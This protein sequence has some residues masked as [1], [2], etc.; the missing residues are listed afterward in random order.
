[1]VNFVQSKKLDLIFPEDIV[2]IMSSI[3]ERYKLEQTDEEVLKQMEGEEKT[4]GEIIAEIIGKTV[5]EEI[6]FQ[7]LVGLLKKNLNISSKEAENLAK[8]LRKEV[9]LLV[10]KSPKEV[11]FLE[12]PEPEKTEERDVYREP[13]E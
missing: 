13:I 1:M 3:L 2:S 10:E 7:E 11:P 6:P 5:E 4:N 8:D 12:K 9:L